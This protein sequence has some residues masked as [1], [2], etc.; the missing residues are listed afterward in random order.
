M[1][2]PAVRPSPALGRHRADTSA[3][4]EDSATGRCECRTVDRPASLGTQYARCQDPPSDAGCVID[5]EVLLR[6][7]DRSERLV[8][9]SDATRE[10]QRRPCGRVWGAA[11][12]S[13]RA[14]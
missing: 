10:R 2:E 8:R 3:A 7:M 6:P 4:R 5:G 9:H 11:D 1:P 12:C 14:L 13:M